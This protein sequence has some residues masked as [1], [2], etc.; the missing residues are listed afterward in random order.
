MTKSK[1]IETMQTK[2]SEKWLE[3]ARYDYSFAPDNG[4]YDDEIKWYTTDTHHQ[5]LLMEWNTLYTLM[6]EMGIAVDYDCS[7]AV[8][9]N[10][11]TAIDLNHDLFIRRENARGIFYN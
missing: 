5:E 6:D 2:L 3:M 11:E 7:E 8:R 4:N 10:Y 9:S 1:M